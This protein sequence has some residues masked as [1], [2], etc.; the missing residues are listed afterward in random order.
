MSSSSESGSW[1]RCSCGGGGGG[2]GGGWKIIIL[3][4]LY[5]NNESNGCDTKHLIGMACIEGDENGI[6]FFLSDNEF[7]SK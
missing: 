7:V 2:G 3:I 5:L 1:R 4:D 6:Y